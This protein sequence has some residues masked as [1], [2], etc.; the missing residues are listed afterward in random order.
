MDEITWTDMGV[1]WGS[2]CPEDIDGRHA[3]YRSRSGA[4]CS[5]DAHLSVADLERSRPWWAV[6]HPLDWIREVEHPQAS[7]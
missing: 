7:E 6:G 5:C 3:A 4:R 2:E 1:V